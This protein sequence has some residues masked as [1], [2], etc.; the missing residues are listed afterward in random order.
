MNRVQ[1]V[2]VLI[3]ITALIVPLTAQSQQNDLQA[4]SKVK[5][6]I[7]TD[8]REYGSGEF[9]RFRATLI[10]AS[11]SAIYVAKTWWYAGGGISGFIVDLKQLTG[12]RSGT[13]CAMAGDRAPLK[14]VR[15]PDQIL[16]ED[17]VRLGR[18]ELIGFEDT[19]RGCIIKYPGTYQITAEY[20]AND[21]NIQTVDALS[22]GKAVVLRGRIQ[23]KP[24]TFRLRTS[25]RKAPE[26]QN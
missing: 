16:R 26:D 17:F 10:N 4:E 12:K 25:K 2:D 7:T 14:D 19:Y 13:G 9:V 20:S 8:K 11:D 18:G 23:S 24:F 5:V 1:A 21:W 6:G 3:T 22:D 15:T